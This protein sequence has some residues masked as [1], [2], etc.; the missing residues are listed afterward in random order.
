M[1]VFYHLYFTL[2]NKKV[3]I[4]VLKGHKFTI[5]SVKSAA[6]ASELAPILDPG[7]ITCADLI[8]NQSVCVF[9]WRRRTETAVTTRF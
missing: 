9:M 3:I 6:N 8:R 7:D 2:F 1:F 5:K 4:L